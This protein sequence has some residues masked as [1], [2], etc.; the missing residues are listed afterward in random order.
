MKEFELLTLA[1]QDGGRLG[2]PSVELLTEAGYPV[3]FEEKVY[4]ADIGNLPLRVYRLR[5]NDIP[6]LVSRGKILMGITGQV[7]IM[8]KNAGVLPL[9]D[10]PFGR[11]DVVVGVDK[12]GSIERVEELQGKT[13]ATSYPNITRGF[14]DNLGVD[15]DLEVLEGKVETAIPEGWAQAIVDVRTTGASQERN[16]IVQIDTVFK[17]AAIKLIANP[18]LR[19]IQG[20]DRW[21]VMLVRDIMSVLRSRENVVM[22]MNVPSRIRESVIATLPSLTAPTEAGL[23]G[24]DFT[25]MKSVVPIKHSRSVLERLLELGVQGILFDRPE[26]TPRILPD[27][28]DPEFLTV[29]RKIYGRDWQPKVV[30]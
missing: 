12:N 20:S 11:C 5:N 15:I 23:A 19:D 17:D 21:V 7:N 28:D 6:D 25:S 10:L 22:E 13:V 9:L 29:M 4:R 8:E 16:G 3:E 2:P 24:K 27:N 26:K 1:I 30:R 14:F 18:E